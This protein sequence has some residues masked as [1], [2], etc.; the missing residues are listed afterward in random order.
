MKAKEKAI[1]ERECN[2]TILEEQ[3]RVAERAQA[4]I[5]ERDK[6]MQNRIQDLEAHEKAQ[7]EEKAQLQRQWEELRV[8]ECGSSNT[9]TNIDVSTMITATILSL[10]DSMPTVAHPH[11]FTLQEFV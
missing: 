1:Q 11:R 6:E 10:S 9:V 5:S 7:Q 4:E 8:K 3:L 2:Q